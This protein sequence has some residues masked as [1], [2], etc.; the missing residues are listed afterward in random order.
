MS[1]YVIRDSIHNRIFAALLFGSGFLLAYYTLQANEPLQTTA[2]MR[3]STPANLFFA[4]MGDFGTGEDSQR[5]VAQH[6]K[7]LNEHAQ[8]IHG[9]VVSA[10]VLPWA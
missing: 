6:L 5:Q 7:Y 10:F 8:R 2:Q 1:Q 4:V 9:D 3:G